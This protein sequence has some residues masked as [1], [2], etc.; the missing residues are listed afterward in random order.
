MKVTRRHRKKAALNLT[1]MID[2][3]FLL[4]IFFMVSSTLVKTRGMAVKLPRS[5][6][7][8]SEPKNLIVISVT[9]NRGIFINE[10]PSSFETLAG[11]L[12]KMR[13]KLNQNVVIIKGDKD[14]AY[15]KMIRVMDLAKLAGMQKISLA[16][17]GK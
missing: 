10:D 7:S 5:V 8:E 12:K 15:Q 3:V 2:I 16:T 13:L 14:S 9:K 6:S 1:P 11:D 4:I 17:T